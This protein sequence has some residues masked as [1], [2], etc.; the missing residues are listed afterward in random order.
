MMSTRF[1]TALIVAAVAIGASAFSP[2]PSMSTSRTAFTTSSR[3]APKSSPA[4]TTALQLKLD[5]KELEKNA[6]ANTKGNM[7]ASPASTTALQLKLDPKELE[8]N[9]AANTKGNMK[10]VAYG[11]SIAIGA[12]LPLAFLVWA[13]IH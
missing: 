6:A 2:Q 7:K 10:G 4:S 12:L 5:P 11:G 8:K 1:F 9:A 13:A 3:Q